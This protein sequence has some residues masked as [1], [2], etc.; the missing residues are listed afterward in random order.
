MAAFDSDAFD[1]DAFSELAFLF[2]GE[3]PE[4][5][6][7]DTQ[8]SGGW[9]FMQYDMEMRRRKKRREELEEA[10]EAT[11][12]LPP[13]EK[14]IAQFLHKQEREDEKRAEVERLKVLVDRYAD[15]G[16]EKVLNQRAKDALKRLKERKSFS[17]TLKFEKELRRQLE[18]EEM[19]FML[20][21]L[22]D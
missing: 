8:P 9:F 21:L 15:E 20:M 19:A 5:E 13:L 4:P 18:E 22:N 1:V 17:S 11:S 3:A 6:P 10:E 16:I 7:A 12:D 2:D 14:E